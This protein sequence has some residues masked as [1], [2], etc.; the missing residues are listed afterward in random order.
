MIS[1]DLGQNHGSKK[2]DW[3]SGA[4]SKVSI[5]ST[6]KAKY[7]LFGTT[8][9]RIP[10]FVTKISHKFTFVPWAV[11]WPTSRIWP[12]V[13]QFFCS[14][15]F[16]RLVMKTGRPVPVPVRRPCARPRTLSNALLSVHGHFKWSIIVHGL[17]IGYSLRSMGI[18]YSTRVQGRVQC[19]LIY[20]NDY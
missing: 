20:S 10:S 6:N 9:D 8:K 14:L 16:R 2:T 4:C 13:N 19:T 1:C 11:I 7:L 18:R 5:K 17:S 12:F 3:L 15:Y